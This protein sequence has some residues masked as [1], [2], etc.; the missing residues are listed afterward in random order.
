MTDADQFRVGDV[1]KTTRGFLYR[2]VSVRVNG[3]AVLRAGATGKRGKIMRKPWDGIGGWV[4]VSCAGET[5]TNERRK[6]D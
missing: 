2:V 6:P 5:L 3:E 4:R 1:W